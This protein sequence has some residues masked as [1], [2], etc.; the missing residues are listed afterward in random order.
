M[1]PVISILLVI[2]GLI[3]IIAGHLMVNKEIAK[4][5][6]LK[7]RAFPNLPCGR[8]VQFIGIAILILG[9]GMPK[10]DDWPWRSMITKDENLLALLENGT[11]V[12]G[13]VVRVYYRRA[14]PK[15]WSMDYKFVVEDP[16][17]HKKETYVGR[18]QG[19]KKYFSGLSA[20]NPVTIIYWPVKPDVNCE[21]RYFLNNPS[22]KHVFKKAGK[23]E[24]LNKFEN[25]YEIEHYSFR[26]WCKL[27]WEK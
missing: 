26:E 8:I 6:R 22:N 25:Q 4:Y 16:Q 12:Q 18:A 20:G 3:I 13:E 1:L 24:L 17:A 19:P 5:Q 11:I 21:I 9:I 27:K 7:Y 10:G 2:F 15:G 23:L 14:A